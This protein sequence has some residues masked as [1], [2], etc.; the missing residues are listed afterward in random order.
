MMKKTHYQKRTLLIILLSFFI[1]GMCQAQSKEDLK[2]V[3]IN[4]SGLSTHEYNS[5]IN[6]ND[7]VKLFSTERVLQL[8]LCKIY[9]TNEAQMKHRFIQSTPTIKDDPNKPQWST[10]PYTILREEDYNEN[11]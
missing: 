1:G 7:T 3:P 5:I 10:I 11:N 6:N 2:G 4:E 8:T 9:G